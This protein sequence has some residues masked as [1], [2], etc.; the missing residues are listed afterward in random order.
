MGRAIRVT[1]LHTADQVLAVVLIHHHHAVGIGDFGFEQIGAI[2][3]AGILGAVV[4]HGAQASRI[5]RGAVPAQILSKSM[6]VGVAG[7]QMGRIG[8]IACLIVRVELADQI[9][10]GFGIEQLAVGIAGRGIA[11]ARMCVAGAVGKKLRDGA[12]ATAQ[13]GGKRAAR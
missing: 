12:D 4:G 9:D 7:Q 11:V 2:G 5:G 13:L 8:I 3:E 6:V 10:A 1:C